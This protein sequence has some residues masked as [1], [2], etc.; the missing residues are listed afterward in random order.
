[1]ELL[2]L[3]GI[4]AAM[5]WGLVYLRWAGLWGCVLS[6]LI[7]GTI[8]GHPF[9]H[10]SWI[11]TDRVLLGIC[12]VLLLIQR[13]LGFAERVAWHWID[14]VVVV[15][16]GII[17]LGTFSHDWRFAD[18]WPLSKFLFC[19]ALPISLYW[20]G[21]QVE[22]TVARLRWMFATF[23]FLGVYLALTAVAEKYG[24]AWA[25]FPRYI[26]SSEF[27]EFL[28]R[29]RGPLLNPVGNGVLLT[30][31]M[32]SALMFIPHVNKV[33]RVAIVASI[34]VFLMGIYC[35][36]TRCVWIG[37]AIALVGIT[38]VGL[39]K[40]FRLPFAMMVVLGGATL[41]ATKSESFTS[42]KRDKNVSV[43]D[44]KQSVQLRPILAAFA[45]KMFQDR[46]LTGCGTGQYLSHVSDYLSERDVDLPLAKAK[47][48]VQHNVFLAFLVE[49]GLVGVIFFTI[50]VS[51][52]TWHGWRLWQSEQRPMEERQLGLVFLSFMAA[53]LANGLFHDLGIVP[54]MGAYFFFGLGLVRNATCSYRRSINRF[55]LPVAR[56]KLPDWTSMISTRSP[57]RRSISSAMRSG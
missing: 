51:W 31:G 9:F 37:G 38:W 53:Y 50:L 25:I 4:A 54:M 18:G 35:T 46:P 34:P 21:R 11:T 49:N 29:G 39:P 57:N 48:Y 33:G 7:A 28:G 43:A 47:D 22:L 12:V 6:T 41:V 32:A 55:A 24:Q 52:S 13:Y 40:R 10:I 14:S 56:G 23:A 5:V 16:F 30:L 27:I 2:L 42:F 15:F 44:M 8:F 19:F 1:M 36:L 17:A 26:A 45:W 20:L 3:L